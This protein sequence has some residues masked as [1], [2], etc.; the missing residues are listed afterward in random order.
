MKKDYATWILLSIC[1]ILILV[2]S[3]VSLAKNGTID[4]NF[5]KSN[6]Q[7]PIGSELSESLNSG[8]RTHES[9]HSSGSSHSDI[10]TNTQ[11]SSLQHRAVLL[12]EGAEYKLPWVD[13]YHR[14]DETSDV[15]IRINSIERSEND[16]GFFI[17]GDKKQENK[18]YIFAEIELQNLGEREFETTL[19][20]LFLIVGHENG[21]EVRGFDSGNP[22]EMT[23]DYYHVTLVP[24]LENTFCLV[25]LVDDDVLNNN[26]NEIFLYASFI[27]SGDFDS[28]LIPIIEKVE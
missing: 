3:I 16:R 13:Q 4:L 11:D 26:Q 7:Q 24:N 15:L 1:I 20:S 25:F 19:N 27:E 12:T 28:D 21:Y 8:L 22:N 5:D 23:Q 10:E 18:S 17:Y 9:N 2:L 14:H 6:P